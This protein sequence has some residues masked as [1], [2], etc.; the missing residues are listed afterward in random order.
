MKGFIVAALVPVILIV[1]L[2]AAV[3]SGT[4]ITEMISVSD[5]T[6]DLGMN[7]TDEVLAYRFLVIQY[8]EE[9]GVSDYVN[10]LLA[11][12]QVE[13]GGTGNDVMQSSESLGMPP[14][15]LGPEASI[16]QGVRYFAS[17][18]RKSEALGCDL[19]TAI[20]A[21]NYGT[22]FID[23]VVEN[24]EDR[25]YTFGLAMEFA[26]IKS[27]G[28][29]VT[30]MDPL[31]VSYNGGWK[32]KYGSMFYVPHVLQYVIIKKFDD[33]TVQA[34]F[35]E[36]LKYEG[37]KYVFGGDRPDTS[38]D[39]SGLTQWCYGKAG[40]ELPR[41]AQRQYEVTQHITLADAEPGDL[42]FFEGT[43]DT[44]VYITHVG[45]YAGNNRMYHA[46]DPIGYADLSDEYWQEHL[47][48]FG[49]V[50]R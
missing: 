12:M 22:G 47:V 30:Y 27:G 32:Y 23:F 45:I 38:F 20:Q 34:V 9:F 8:A 41:T 14:D 21:Y 6:G 5:V 13:S 50:K 37:W 43:Y 46:G 4:E 2:V 24:S 26:R 11:I 33:E 28:E 25:Q 29:T 39:C 3:P 31:A 42:V 10:Y 18:L 44:D 49:R 15:T 36:A 17:C 16:E 1:M 48:C 7:L 19:K 35:D 40:T